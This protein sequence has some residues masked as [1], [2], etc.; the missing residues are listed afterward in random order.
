M[1]TRRGNI[2]LLLLSALVLQCLYWPLSSYLNAS[3]AVPRDHIITEFGIAEIDA[4]TL[5]EALH[6]E[7]LTETVLWRDYIEPPK[8]LAFKGEFEIADIPEYDIGIGAAF[9]VD[10]YALYVNGFLVSAYGRL[11]HPSTYHGKRREI[12]RVSRGLLRPGKNEVLAL[13]AQ[14]KSPEVA[15][16]AM[17]IGDYS[18]IMEATKRKRFMFNQYKWISIIVSGLLSL[19]CFVLLPRTRNKTL[20]LWLG[21]LA[22]A[23]CLRVAFNLYF[24]SFG[25]GANRSFIYHAITALI[26]VA[27][28][29]F[30]N[31]WCD[32]PANSRIQK[33]TTLTYISLLAVFALLIF[34]TIDNG[35]K[36]T[37][38]IADYTGLI[39]MIVAAAR[40]VWHVINHDEPRYWEFGI[41]ALGV[42]LTLI[43]YFTFAFFKVDYGHSNIV[44]LIILIGLVGGIL[45]RS[46]GVFESLGSMNSELQDRLAIRE[47]EIRTRFAE[48]EV[49]RRQRDI[50]NER[51]RILR[52]MHDGIGA[53][54]V[55]LLSAAR[56]G[57]LKPDA[58]EAAITQSLTDLRLM[59]DSLDSV[60]SDFAVALG[61]FR[62][63]ILP[64]LEASG[65]TFNWDLDRLPIGVEVAPKTVLNIYRILQEA[66]AN[67]I[68]HADANTISVSLRPSEP[69]DAT[70]SYDIEISDNGKGFGQRV[71]SKGR[72]LSSMKKRAKDIGATITITD[73]AEGLTILIGQISTSEESAKTVELDYGTTPSMG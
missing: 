69:D 54:L 42:S 46:I 18:K 22:G 52:D 50:A 38:I 21:I 17:L 4:P 1:S 25:G 63:R 51:Q 11:E 67:V 32:V 47:E 45:R 37:Q 65:Y 59:I 23:I 27:W 56:S 14:N 60:S 16:S 36:Y 8:Y 66:I 34:S 5:E 55:V 3:S 19:L 49:I 72:G 73:S 30:A 28:L 15:V 44:G 68:R 10:N 43:D 7:F 40:I 57:E 58:L 35:L 48:L 29:G 2:A 70:E 24:G 31:A 53:Q 62:M 61:T 71:I 33:T 26:P 41:I 64:T 9:F 13:G 6:A 39:L 20:P 12:V